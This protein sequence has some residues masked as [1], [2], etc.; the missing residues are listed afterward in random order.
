MT[1][2]WGATDAGAGVKSYD[3]KRSYDGGAYRL[4]ASGVTATS[5]TST[6]KPGHTYRFKVRARDK[7]GNVSGWVRAA[8][9]RASLIQ[10]SSTSVKYGGAWA[11]EPSSA[12]SGGSLRTA[13]AAGASARLSFSGRAVAWVTTLRPDAGQVRVYIDGVLAATIDTRADATAA[14]YVAFSRSWTSWGS[15]T[16]RLVV[17]GTADRPRVDLDAFEVIG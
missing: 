9:W 1:V 14:R 4:V 2:S 5:L 15:H 12:Y 10:Q 3:V 7:A 16:I 6:M 8:T 11:T 13:S 17:L